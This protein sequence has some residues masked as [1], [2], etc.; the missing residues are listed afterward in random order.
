MEMTKKAT[1]STA[2]KNIL[3]RLLA[4]E[5]LT[6]EH[7]AK[8]HTAAF[9]TLSRTLILPIWKDMNNS[10]YDMLVGHEV[11]HALWTPTD[12]WASQ[13]NRKGAKNA[14]S[15]MTF[16]NI[17]EDARI[18]R[19]IKSKFP[20]LRRD[21]YL[22]YK[23]LN[24]RDLFDIGG[25]DVSALTLIDRLNLHFKIGAF[26]NVPFSADE[27]QWVDAVENTKTFVE[28]CDVAS[29]LFDLHVDDQDEDED[30]LFDD[31]EDDSEDDSEDDNQEKTQDDSGENG[32]E[33]NDED[34]DTT[35]QESSDDSSEGDNGSSGDTNEDGDEDETDTD[36]NA[37]VSYDNNKLHYGG[38]TQHAFDKAIS[39]MTDD[40]ARERDYVDIPMPNLENIINDH[41]VIADD[42][43]KFV[44]KSGADVKQDM[45]SAALLMNEFINESKKT[46]TMMA[47]QFMRRQS[48]DEQHRT[49]TSQTGIL[50]VNKMINYKWSDD[51]FLKSEAIADGKNH[52]LVL[53]IDWSGSMS[54]IIG[55]TIKQLMQ[56]VLFCKKVG[57]PFE[58]Y[59]FTSATRQRAA[60][61]RADWDR[62]D[63]PEK[64]NYWSGSHA[65]R[66]QDFNL[67]NY[68]SSRMNT[69]QMK[70]GMI[71]LMYISTQL[72]S[73]SR[74]LPLGHGLGST[75]LNEA[76]LAAIEIVPEFQQRNNVQI[77]NTIILTDGDASSNLLNYN[78]HG[79]IRDPKTKMTFE[80]PSGSYQCDTSLLLEALK[81]RTK[82]KAI[83]MY[84]STQKK[85]SYN[86]DA[87]QV[88]GYEKDGFTSTNR[89]GYSEYFIIKVNNKIQN[90]GL[91]ML[92]EDATYTKIKNTFIKQSAGRVNSRILLNR[93]I[94]L[95]AC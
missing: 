49:M 70:Q 91:E 18:E 76:I 5:N 64:E 29:D 80:A 72:Q 32:D 62:N 16:V 10:L 12:E 26:I 11:A 73:Y 44:A 2:S 61:G 8:A 7:S 82:A 92:G 21:F 13:R 14:S 41:T 40:T 87:K 51:L 59:S 55:D 43:A 27:Q 93:V 30:G 37:E 89:A 36:E 31:L 6:V 57:I 17:V 9:D 75:P 77:V 56:L 81:S 54:H 46:I 22:A 88:A 28:V 4:A 67:N 68:L 66:A 65:T 42:I 60:L 35:P 19:N 71:N 52:G 34:G 94:D 47:Q 50:D 69:R 74:N 63:L 90:D 33:T 86:T 58:V 78:M 85:L 95:I 39:N 53:F 24:D 1:V 15:Y 84:L 45:T 20:G 79:V 25:K 38:L 83:G 48:A 23:N 3:A